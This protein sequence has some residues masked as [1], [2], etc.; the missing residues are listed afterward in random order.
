MLTTQA[1]LGNSFLSWNFLLIFLLQF[2]RF[3]VCPLYNYSTDPHTIFGITQNHSCNPNCRLYPCYINEGDIQKPLLVVF[4]IRDIEP[5]AEICFNYQGTYPGEEDE[6]EE[7]ES[8]PE[9]DND[10]PKDKI[11]TKCLCG[12]RNCRGDVSRHCFMRSNFDTALQE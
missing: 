5:D 1:M 2:T 8:R 10:E 3:L 12:A 7:D 6:D 11:Y 9:E 4:S